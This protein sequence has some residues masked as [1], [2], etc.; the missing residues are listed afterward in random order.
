MGW[1]ILKKFWHKI[2]GGKECL[3]NTLEK[4]LRMQPFGLQPD[5]N[6]FSGELLPILFNYLSS[7]SQD[8]NKDLRGVNKTYYALE[9]FC[10]NLGESLAFVRAF[11]WCCVW[12]AHVAV[13]PSGKTWNNSVTFPVRQNQGM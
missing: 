9:V 12:R 3:L 10:E 11:L 2:E 7:A 6:K 1:E 4:Q 8:I 5:I 13:F